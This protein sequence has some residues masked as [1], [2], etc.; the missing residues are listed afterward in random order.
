MPRALLRLVALLVCV[1]LAAHQLG[2]LVHE[3]LGHGGATILNGGHIDAVHLFWAGGGFVSST[4]DGTVISDVFIA[5]GGVLAQLAAG[6]LIWFTARGPSFGAQLLRIGAALQWIGPA[7]YFAAGIWEG[8][9]DGRN[10]T[11]YGGDER[12][13]FAIVV[14]LAGCIVAFF[15]ARVLAGVIAATLP[16][17]SIARFAGTVAAV[18]ITVA[19]TRGLSALESRIRSDVTYVEVMTPERDRLIAKELAAW[20]VQRPHAIDAERAAE[21]NVVAEA[22]ETFPFGI[23]HGLAVIAALCAGGVLS[24]RRPYAPIESRILGRAALVTLSSSI[25]I[26]VISQ[27]VPS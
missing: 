13:V 26:I 11:R 24:R 9:G 14:A 7:R 17:G 18:I 12:L 5:L 21:A 6:L 3:L 20:E 27:L 8:Y 2:T 22:H 1:D 10:F 4:A 15:T 25:A 23:V 19:T 16:G